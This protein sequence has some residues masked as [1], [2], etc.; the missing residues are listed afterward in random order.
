MVA[1]VVVAAAYLFCGGFIQKIKF[2]YLVCLVAKSQGDL[3]SACSSSRALN[4]TLA[5]LVINHMFLCL[6]QQYSQPVFPSTSLI[7]P[8]MHTKFHFVTFLT[9]LSH[10]YLFIRVALETAVFN[11][12]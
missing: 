2:F 11:R 8:L 1:V 12:L 3:V 9:S 4:I 10:I 7:L 5:S 6:S